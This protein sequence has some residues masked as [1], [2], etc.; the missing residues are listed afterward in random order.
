MPRTRTHNVRIDGYRPAGRCH[1]RRPP[2]WGDL[3]ASGSWNLPSLLGDEPTQS[4]S[5]KPHHDGRGAHLRLLQP[6][7]WV[8]SGTRR[9]VGDSVPRASSLH[10]SWSGNRIRACQTNSQELLRH[11]DQR[12]PRNSRSRPGLGLGYTIK[13]LTIMVLGGVKSPLGPVAGGLL[14]GVIELLV[15]SLFDAYWVGAVSLIIL[16]SILLTSPTGL[17]GS[18]IR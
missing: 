10:C 7:R 4:R 2:A 17:T 3:R 5:R 18:R 11:P 15:A 13:L 8:G 9:L 1:H 6:P 14:L 12:N 16:I